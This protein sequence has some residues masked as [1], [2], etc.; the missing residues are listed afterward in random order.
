MRL[1]SVSR[2]LLAG[3]GALIAAVLAMG[4]STQ[5]LPV[6]PSGIDNILYPVL[7]F[8][9][10]WAVFFF[11]AVIFDQVWKAALLFTGVS[12]AHAYLVF[13]SFSAG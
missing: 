5:W 3:P 7:L 10:I 13:T 1:Q 12:V 11:V 6:G 2:C 8:P 4:G 9:G